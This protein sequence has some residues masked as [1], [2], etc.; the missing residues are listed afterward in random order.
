MQAAYVPD[1]SD[2]VS[3]DSNSMLGFRPEK[4]V[5]NSKKRKNQPKQ[6]EPGIINLFL[7]T[8]AAAAAATTT[9][10]TTTTAAAWT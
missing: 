1:D 3:S 5:S 9:T 2:S 10:K 6:R 4:R 8:S 7:L